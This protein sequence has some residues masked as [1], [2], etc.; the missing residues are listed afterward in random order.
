MT[1]QKP[2]ETLLS[3]ED[4]AKALGRPLPTEEQSAIISSPLVPRLVVAG[5]GSGK[6]ATMV[7]RVVWL[8]ANGLVRADQVL[9]VTFTRKAAGELRERMRSRLEE[10]RRQGIVRE[11][12]DQ[13]ADGVTSDPT[14]STYHS[15]ANTL[16][17]QYGLRIGVEDD[18]QML[19]GAQTWQL[20]CSCLPC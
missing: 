3:P 17:Q 15:Y 8:V 6:T 20:V 18:A 5:A 10:L 19:G 14:I 4:I 9:G 16:V 11:N 12:P 13:S 2:A 7:D 1:E